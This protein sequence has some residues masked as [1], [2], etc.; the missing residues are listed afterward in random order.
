MGKY[1]LTNKAIRDLSEIWN[2]TCDVWSEYQADKYYHELIEHCRELAKNPQMGRRY[3]SILEKL[4]GFK[5]NRHI[6][7]Y[8]VSRKDEIEIV[9]ILY[10]KM[11]L[12]NRIKE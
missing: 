8:R 5:A 6:I 9:R 11:D 12:K 2:Y 1:N 3:D 10:E 4:Q 7:F